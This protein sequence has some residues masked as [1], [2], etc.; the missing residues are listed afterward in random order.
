MIKSSD[1]NINNAYRIIKL[2][3]NQDYLAVDLNQ[4]Y[5]IFSSTKNIPLIAQK[6]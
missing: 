2:L 6:R 3:T 5:Y 1:N 4:K